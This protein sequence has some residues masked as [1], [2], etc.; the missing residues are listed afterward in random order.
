MEVY[1]LNDDRAWDHQTTEDDGLYPRDDDEQQVPTSGRS[2]GTQSFIP[3]PSVAQSPATSSH[4]GSFMNELA[5]RSSQQ[6]GGQPPLMHSLNSQQNQG[7]L[8]D[9]LS[10]NGT[11][12]SVNSNGTGM[13]SVDMMVGA[14]DNRRSSAFGDYN[15]GNSGMYTTSWQPSTTPTNPQPP[16]GGHQHSQPAPSYVPTVPATHTQQSYVS[17]AYVDSMPRP[18]YNSHQNQLF[19]TGDIPPP[20]LISQHSYTY[21]DGRPMPSLPGV[22]EVI[23]SV[24][25]G[26]RSGGPL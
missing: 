21:N 15:S 10:V 13:G 24:P 5:V 25:L 2:N 19:R 18:S 22:S 11:A 14:H 26:A 17:G 16:Y 7:M 9:G 6:P 20:P 12:S 23:D 8:D 3:T 1:V 4:T